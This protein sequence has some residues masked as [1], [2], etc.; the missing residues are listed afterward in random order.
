MLFINKNITVAG[1]D[2]KE[3]YVRMDLGKWDL[4]CCYILPNIPMEEYTDKV[5][6]ICNKISIRKKAQWYLY[7]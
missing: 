7:T 2:R 6:E 4:Y 3:G 5:D 1:V